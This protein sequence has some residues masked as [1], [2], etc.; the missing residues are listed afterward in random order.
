MVLSKKS[1]NP[2]SCGQNFIIVNE[3]FPFISKI[4]LDLKDI[5]AV[6]I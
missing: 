5:S 3:L 2:K 1:L 6:K 4:S